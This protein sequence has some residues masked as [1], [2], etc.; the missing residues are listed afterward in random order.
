VAG[1]LKAHGSYTKPLEVGEQGNVKPAPDQLVTRERLEQWLAD[2]ADIQEEL[3]NAVLAADPERI[4]F[5]VEKGADIN[6]L[7][8]QGYGPL[9]SAAR[10]RDDKI[11][12]LLIKLKANANGRDKDGL[13]ALIYATQRN[14]V[15]S[16]KALLANGADIEAPAPGGFA[17]LA[18]AI[19]EGK[20]LAA[21]ELI[22]RGAVIDTP[23]G[24]ERVTPLMLAAS[25]LA[26]GEQAKEIEQRQGLRSTDI[27][28]ALIA[29]GANV[30]A[31]NSQG[32]TAL[33]IAAARGNIP[34]IGLLLESG[35]DPNAKSAA[36]KT[37]LDIARDNLNEGAV[38]SIVLFEKTLSER[39]QPSADAPPTD[40]E[41][42]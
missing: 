15:P 38:K 19:E 40:K 42:M 24:L 12:P 31:A 32:V 27:A 33:M 29:R 7:D 35:A 1:D 13:T 9:Q 20:F 2:G 36:G 21:K 39:T 18:L 6:G 5:L 4:R 3:A 37:A 10:N 22:E 11:I 16:V 30:N 28:S 26:V 14:H 41:K 8:R 25:W 23:A 17:P 34:M